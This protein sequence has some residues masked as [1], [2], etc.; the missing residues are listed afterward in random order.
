MPGVSTEQV[1]QARQV[2]LLAYLQA[3]EPDNLRRA[4]GEYHLAD[5]DSLKISP[6]GMWNWHSRGFGG[7][8][9]LDFLIKVRG[10]SFV[11]AVEALCDGRAVSVPAQPQLPSRPIRQEFSL[12]PKSP[13]SY[14]VKAYLESRGISK[15]LIDRC[16]RAGFLYE[17]TPYHN[18]VF[19]GKDR[20]GKAR[21]ACARGT[22]GSFKR[23]VAGSDKRFGFVLPPV[24]PEGSGTLAVFESPID[25]LSHAELT[26]EDC[27]RLS[28]AG[29]APLA[30]LHFL[31][32][33][34]E[35]GSPDIRHISLC[36]DNDAAGLTAS[37]DI[38]SLLEKDP[39]FA[40]ITVTHDQPRLGKDYNETLLA[41]QRGDKAQDRRHTGDPS[42]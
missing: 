20:E 14:R 9:T 26:G 10:M 42:L 37:A 40:H 12:P 28:L 33:A 36:L 32:E 34:H 4:G 1:E 38:K 22:L 30:L 5:H 8:S 25:A 27:H 15:A 18:A 24:S 35:H 41:H 16:I 23:D 31:V 29:T 19:V 3:H 7:R 2:N 39:R 21:F 11:S 6:N 13:S 17:S